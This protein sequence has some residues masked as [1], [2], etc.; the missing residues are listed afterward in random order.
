MWDFNI[1]HLDM[2]SVVHKHYLVQLCLCSFGTEF[3]IEGYDSE[4]PE[5]PW[6]WLRAPYVEGTLEKYTQCR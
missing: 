5:Q 3:V 6:F 4:Y 2:S 1:K